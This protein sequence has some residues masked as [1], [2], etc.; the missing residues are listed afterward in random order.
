MPEISRNRQNA[1]YAEDV[2]NVKDF[3]AVGD[4]VTDDTAAIQAAINSGANTVIVS[5][6][7]YIVSASIEITST[8]NIELQGTIKLASSTDL[9]SADSESGILEPSAA[10]YV[11]IYGTGTI[12]CNARGSASV[13]AGVSFKTNSHNGSVKGIRVRDAHRNH[14]RVNESDDVLIAHTTCDRETNPATA[15]RE[16]ITVINGIRPNIIHNRIIDGADACIGVHPNCD[17]FNI[18]NNSIRQVELIGPAIDIVGLINN[19]G[20]CS[21]NEITIDA[22]CNQPTGSAIRFNNEQSASLVNQGSVINAI[23]S[24]NTVYVESGATIGQAI[25]LLGGEDI[26]IHGNSLIND[27]AATYGIEVIDTTK[28]DASPIVYENIIFKDNFVKGFTAGVNINGT[29]QTSTVEG[30][31]FK[32]CTTAIWQTTLNGLGSNTYINCTNIVRAAVSAMT[33]MKKRSLQKLVFAL[34]GRATSGIV[35]IPLVGGLVNYR[36]EH[37]MYLVGFAAK[38]DAAPSGGNLNFNLQNNTTNIT[39]ATIQIA[40]GDS[41]LDKIDTAFTNGMEPIPA[42][43]TI[44]VETTVSATLGS[45][46]DCYVEVYYFIEN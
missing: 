19:G 38:V 12:D 43:N 6:G 27:G 36:A 28:S 32:D 5:S 16:S 11:N 17:G 37:D 14:I 42:G 31:V 2:V 15:S 20:V 18:S 46:V 21:G 40:N 4:G 8:I 10:T 9:F 35:D 44:S 13:G 41:D 23:V 1:R 26:N 29:N 24:N 22:T 25:R 39:G 3:G 33:R 30:N 7:E 34:E 45:T